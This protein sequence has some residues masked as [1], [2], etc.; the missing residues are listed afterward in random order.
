MTDLTYERVQ[1]HLLRLKLPRM[2]EQVDAVAAEA[3][4]EEWTYLA[5]L[6]NL[7]DLEVSSRYARDVAM[8]TKLAHLPF[9]KTLD[10]FDFAFQP[11]I[12]ERQVRELAG[13][14]FLAHGENVLLLGPPGV[15]KT[16]LAIALGMAAIA[17][18]QSVY[19]LTIVDLLEMLHRDAKE[20][21]LGHRLRTLCKPK[22]L[23]LDEMGY[24]P[25]DRTAAHFLFQLVSRRYQKGSIILTSNKSFGEWGE[26]FTD[27]VLA[28]A[29]LDRLL[30]HATTINI[31]GNSYRLRQKQKTGL[32]A[33]FALSPQEE[34]PASATP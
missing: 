9:A 5:F 15:G 13:M 2:A 31:R 27:A 20:D 32:P 28:T 8:K 7:L 30:H 16:H 33:D 6:D 12:N 22:L 29:I 18:S 24:F 21:R 4:K 26:I 1:S 11:S 17:Q 10:Q 34:S 14:R 25:V 3:A 19:F 23:I